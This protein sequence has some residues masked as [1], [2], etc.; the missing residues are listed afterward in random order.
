MAASSDQTL[1]PNPAPNASPILNIVLNQPEIPGNTG[2]V[3]RTCVALG[4]KLWLVRPL[5]FRVDEKTLRRAGLDYWRHLDW[6]VADHWADLTDRLRPARIWL[7]SRF[8]E[9]SYLTAQFKR[10]DTLVFGSET[11]GLPASLTDR[12]ADRLLR[13]PTTENVRSLNLATSVGVAAFEA[14]RQIGPW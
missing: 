2:A 8:A 10:G 6:E 9:K 14:A 12:F 3:G 5:G 1:D 11:T 13:I 4:A 7:F